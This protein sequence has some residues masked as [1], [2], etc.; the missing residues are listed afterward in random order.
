M[1]TDPR[2]LRPSELCRLLNSTSLGE[3]MNER[4]MHRHRTRAGLRI[5]DTK[6]IDLL[7]YVAWLIDVKH[8][9]KK[10]SDEELYDRQKERARSRAAKMA[11]EGR[12]IRE[13]P[14]VKNPRR[15]KAAIKSFRMFCESYFP[16]LFPLKWSDDHLTVIRRIEDSVMHGGLFALAMPRGSGKTTLCQVG[17]IWAAFTGRREFICFFAA[18]AAIAQDNLNDIKAELEGNELLAEDWPEICVPIQ[19]LEGLSARCKGQL[20]QGKRTHVEWQKRQVVLPAIAD[21]PASGVIIRVAGITGSL[22]G[23][24]FTR[25]DGRSVRPSLVIVDDPQTDRSASSLMQCQVRENLLAGAIL[26]LAGP[27]EKIAGVMPCTVIRGGDMAD[28]ILDRK[29]HPE[30]QGERFRMVYEFPTE[31]KLWD[32]Y[33][34]IRH[35]DL[36]AGGDGR[37]ATKYYRANRKAMD[38][39][40][41]IAWPQRKNSDELSGLQHAINLRLRD[42]EAFWS[43]CQNE[44]RK[45]DASRQQE[46]VADELAKRVNGV[47]RGTVPL[48]CTRLTAYVDVQHSLL[49]WLVAAWSDDFTG[50][51]VDYGT[52]PDQDRGYFTLATAQRTLQVASPG[53]SVQAAVLSGL[54]SLSGSLLSREWPREDGATMRLE[55]MLVDAKDGR[56]VDT[57]TE[58]CRT[59]Q[60]ASL[61]IPSSGKGIGPADRPMPEY[62]I[63]PGERL[64]FHWL[65]ARMGKRAVRHVVVDTNFWKSHVQQALLLAP[66]E[67]GSIVICGKHRS[68]QRMLADHCVSEGCDVMTSEKSGRTSAVWKLKPNRPDNHWWDC[69]VGSA[70]AASMLGV[71]TM[72]KAMKRAAS[73][74]PRRRVTY[75]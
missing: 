17:C 5:G 35:D 14:E 36:A 50:A 19:R 47:T 24:K 69:L 58:F 16:H 65:L 21:S 10:L 29:K 41:R 62:T 13:L 57:I 34:R 15:K 22:R 32:E 27:T 8:N 43:E 37:R 56:L 52:F 30:W 38:A 18:A 31:E 73:P 75:L 44:P 2:K 12:D 64:G 74:Q 55:R 67:R 7:K 70:V 20:F 23:M 39:G 28:A 11:L 66:G 40:A 60:W 59:S 25:P 49:Y 53:V 26:G 54:Q 68:D 1:A 48:A 3:V 4:Q 45:N 72:G 42:E 61:L 46:L 63:K 6:T 33:A 51:I 9:T 71:S